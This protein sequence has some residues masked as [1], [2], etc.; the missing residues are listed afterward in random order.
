MDELLAQIEQLPMPSKVN[1]NL[2]GKGSTSHTFPR[3]TYIII[4]L[5]YTGT[6]LINEALFSY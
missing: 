2:G 5:L 4:I 1:P 3:G 6:S